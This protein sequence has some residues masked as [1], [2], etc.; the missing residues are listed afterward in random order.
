MSKMLEDLT[1]LIVEDEVMTA[2]DVAAT[3]EDARGTVLGPCSTVEHALSL[4][5]HHT[6]NA[7]ILDVNLTD[8]DITQVLERLLAHGIFVIVYSSASLPKEMRNRHP[9]LPFFQKPMPHAV[10]TRTLMNAF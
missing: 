4:I 9:N 6:I 2:M 3:I 7:A 8:G 10:L 1:I 5:E